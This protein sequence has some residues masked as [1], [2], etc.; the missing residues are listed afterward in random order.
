MEVNPDFAELPKH[1]ILNESFNYML[2]VYINDYIV[3]EIPRS[4][5]QLHHVAN[6]IMTGMHDVFPPDKYDKK[7]A[8]PL[9][10]FLKEEAAWAII[11]NVPEFEFGGNPGTH[12]ICLTEDHHTNILT[13]L[14]RWIR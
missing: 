11:K 1:Y 12:T 7:D 3:L 8:I 14:K 10:I 13:K 4:Q 2:E 9:K 5:Y 6:A